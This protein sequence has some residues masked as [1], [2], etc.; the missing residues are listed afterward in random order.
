[1]IDTEVVL[2]ALSVLC[3]D[4]VSCAQRQRLEDGLPTADI[5]EGVAKVHL[6]IQELS[7]KDLIPIAL[8]G[9]RTR[10]QTLEGAFE[11][12]P[13]CMINLPNDI[14]KDEKTGQIVIKPE[15]YLWSEEHL[16]PRFNYDFT[17]LKD[18]KTYY[19]GGELYKRPCGW[20]RFALK[21]L[22]KY[23]DNTWLGHNWRTTESV[24]GEWPVSYHGTD[25]KFVKAIIE[26]HLKAGNR[27]LYGKGIYSTPDIDIAKGFATEFTAKK[28]KKKYKVILQTRINPE[29]RE[30]YNDDKYWM[31]PISE[32]ASDQEQQEKV[33]NAIRPYGLLLQE[34]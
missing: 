7:I 29:H 22:D 28:T 3:K 23:D 31:V 1:M 20:Q 15:D 11:K 13:V 25:Q 17:K 14:N 9:D 6:P 26:Q 34:I 8:C 19:R 2:E 5:L 30:K 32:D 4:G 27:K 33:E 21:V 24:P 12:L 18:T 16:D 10:N